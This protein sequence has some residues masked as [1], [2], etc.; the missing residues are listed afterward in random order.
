MSKNFWWRVDI[1][2]N[3][4]R[5]RSSQVASPVPSVVC[6]SQPSMESKLVSGPMLGRPTYVRCGEMRR[7]VVAYTEGR[8]SLAIHC[9]GHGAAVASRPGLDC[10]GGGGRGWERAGN[11]AKAAA[12]WRGGSLR[13]TRGSHL[14]DARGNPDFVSRSRLDFPHSERIKV[15]LRQA[16]PGTPSMSTYI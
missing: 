12:V 15:P 16:H 14:N 13:G 4:F 2:S 11:A 1:F 6:L 3:E 5:E 9:C 7:N 10:G 8:E